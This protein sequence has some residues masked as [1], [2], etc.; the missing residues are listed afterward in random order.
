MKVT[1]ELKCNVGWGEIVKGWGIP[2]NVS[3]Y[4]KYTILGGELRQIICFMC[5]SSQPSPYH[6]NFLGKILWGYEKKQQQ[7]TAVRGDT[8]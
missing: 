4:R 6:G 3:F 2:L 8:M 1:L 5:L 7:Q